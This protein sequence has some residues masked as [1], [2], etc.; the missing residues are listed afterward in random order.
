MPLQAGIEPSRHQP[1]GALRVKAE[2]SAMN[3]NGLAE[4][5]G[6]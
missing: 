2:A 6:L 5:N 1:S 3:L 4:R